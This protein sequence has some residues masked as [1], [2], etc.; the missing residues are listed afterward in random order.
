MIKVGVN[1]AGR[2]GRL[3]IRILSQMDSVTL[4]AI[5]DPAT[6]ANTLAHLINF[7]SVNGRSPVVVEALG[8]SVQ[9]GHST[10][11]VTQSKIL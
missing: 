8:D 10:A 7:D 4:M 9:L 6:D 5:N 11:R 2:I 1:G 3:A